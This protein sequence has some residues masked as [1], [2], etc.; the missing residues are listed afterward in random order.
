MERIGKFT[1]AESVMRSEVFPYVMAK[2]R[3]V[4]YRVEFIYH[5]RAAEYIGF[6]W[7]F[8]EEPSYCAPREYVLTVS[9][10]R[11]EDGKIIDVEVT[12]S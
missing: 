6:S 12:V 4:P 3:F 2:M 11:D 8:D 10:V 9:D 1:V 5:Q 7:M